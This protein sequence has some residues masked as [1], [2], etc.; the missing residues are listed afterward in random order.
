MQVWP[1]VLDSAV[2]VQWVALTF[3]EGSAALCTHRCS[4]LQLKVVSLQVMINAT[5][6]NGMG[7]IG[8][9]EGPPR[10]EPS[11]AGGHLVNMQF[12]YSTSLWPWSGYLAI[13]IRINA[14]G[15]DYNGQV[16]EFGV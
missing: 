11:D 3:D 8:H 4:L 6:L 7:V 10:F 16:R 2:R 1:L 5:I 12:E 14:D 9:L 13:Y 15:E